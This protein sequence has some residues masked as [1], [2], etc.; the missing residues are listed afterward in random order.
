[1][2][3]CFIPNLKLK[4]EDSENIKTERVN[5]V[6]LTYIKL[7]RGT[8]LDTR[9]FGLGGGES[10][11]IRW[12][13]ATGVLNLPPCSGVEKAKKYTLFWNQER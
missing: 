12:V 4:Y 3:D 7:N 5:A 2:L 10:T 8:F 1:M 9:Y 13:C 6:D 11:S